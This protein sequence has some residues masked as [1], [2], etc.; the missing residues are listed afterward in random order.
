MMKTLPPITRQQQRVLKLW[1]QPTMAPE[2]ATVGIQDISP[3]HLSELQNWAFQTL[4]F[5]P[6]LEQL[7]LVE[8]EAP[9]I[10]SMATIERIAAI[11]RNDTTGDDIVV[12]QPGQGNNPL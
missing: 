5:Q 1:A 3:V 6:I 2:L 11:F 9:L 7:W 4:A 8:S 12:H 10:V